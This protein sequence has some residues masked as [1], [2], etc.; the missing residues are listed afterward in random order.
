MEFPG[1][2]NRHSVKAY[3]SRIQACLQDDQSRQNLHDRLPHEAVDMLVEKLVG[4]FR[5]ISVAVACLFRST[6]LK[7][8]AK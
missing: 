3:I 8:Q 4:R 7:Q 2:T 5:P 6:D 1:W